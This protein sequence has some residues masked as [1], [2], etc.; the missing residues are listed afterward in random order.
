MEKKWMKY[1]GFN[2][3][4]FFGMECNLKIEKKLKEQ[5]MEMD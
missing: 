3:I 1:K 4:D 5:K 2:L